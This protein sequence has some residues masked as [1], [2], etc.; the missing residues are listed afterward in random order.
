MQWRQPKVLELR[1]GY[2]SSQPSLQFLSKARYLSTQNS[3]QLA[4]ESGT[5]WCCKYK[6]IS[7]PSM[8]V[9]RPLWRWRSHCGSG[10]DMPG[11]SLVGFVKSRNL[12]GQLQEVEPQTK[13]TK[14]GRPVKN[15]KENGKES[16][17]VANTLLL[18][19]K[20]EPLP[21]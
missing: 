15:R 8:K 5:R 17:G 9:G 2:A 16:R 13:K 6:G 19:P 10:P 21:M 3:C 12:I 11:C 20:V 4:G 14:K 1:R 18:S 7:S